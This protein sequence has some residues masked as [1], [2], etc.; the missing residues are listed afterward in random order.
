MDRVIANVRGN[1][2]RAKNGLSTSAEK[3]GIVVCKS[4]GTAAEDAALCSSPVVAAK[5]VYLGG[6]IVRGDAPHEDLSKHA[7]SKRTTAT[8]QPVAPVTTTSA[9]AAAQA[10]RSGKVGAPHK[11]AA[12]RAALKDISLVGCDPPHPP[13]PPPVPPKVFRLMPVLV[14]TETV[15]NP[16][17]TW[18]RLIAHEDQQAVTTEPHLT[19]QFWVGDSPQTLQR[20]GAPISAAMIPATQVPGLVPEQYV[21]V[22]VI[23]AEGESAVSQPV[24][25]PASG[26]V[27]IYIEL[28]RTRP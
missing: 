6:N 3:R 12:D 13:P 21:A 22:S 8:L 7:E 2:I 9:C 15:E 25:Y 24:K 16:T 1:Y 28:A 5:A 20:T 14:S 17:V 27:T 19:Y 10:I 4:S 26:E 11:N 18:K 23:S